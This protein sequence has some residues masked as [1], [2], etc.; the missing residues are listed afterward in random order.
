VK[1]HK[2]MNFS[3][4]L[5]NKVR[6]YL[7]NKLQTEPSDQDILECCQSLYYLGRARANYHKQKLL[8]GFSGD[9]Q[10]T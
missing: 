5:K 1:V 10:K 7:K 8:I 4:E 2:G 6:T 3:V 9:S